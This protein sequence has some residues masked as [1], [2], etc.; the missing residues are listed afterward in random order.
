MIDKNK[1]IEILKKYPKGLKAK[2]IADFIVGVDR[3]AINQ[4]LYANPNIFSCNS[5]YEWTLISNT[6]IERKAIPTSSINKEQNNYID[7][8]VLQDYKNYYVKVKQGEYYCE[9]K[10]R[11]GTYHYRDIVLKLYLVGE[12]TYVVKSSE[13]DLKCPF[14]GNIFSV[15]SFSCPK[16]GRTMQDVCEKLYTDGNVDGQRF[17]ITERSVDEYSVQERK[18]KIYEAVRSFIRSSLPSMVCDY[19]KEALDEVHLN[20]LVMIYQKSL[21]IEKVEDEINDEIERGKKLVFKNC[22]RH[23][24]NDNVEAIVL[25]WKYFQKYLEYRAGS[26]RLKPSDFSIMLKISD[27]VNKCVD[28]KYFDG[29]YSLF[30]DRA[31]KCL[32]AAYDNNI[33][34][35]YKAC[36]GYLIYL[37]LINKSTSMKYIRDMIPEKI[38]GELD[39]K[40]DTIYQTVDVSL[41]DT[42]EETDYLRNY[43]K[44]CDHYCEKVYLKIPLLLSNGAIIVRTVLGTYCDKCK[45]YFVLDTEFKKILCEG[46]IQAQISFSESGEHFSGMDLSPES[47]LRKCGYT[48]SA[49]ANISTEHRQRLLKAII[50]NKLYTPAKIVTH[51]RF[52]ISINNNVTTRDMSVAISK[53]QEDIL[54]LQQHYS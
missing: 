40:N 51:F 10:A 53:W 33:L 7:R 9:D 46:R 11:P 39:L 49:N 19:F 28:V 44:E 37:A 26:Y 42:I 18:R 54:Y 5:N 34:V 38:Y 8:E 35:D 29:L 41:R 23:N 15:H 6:T 14:C 2:D 12:K 27:E 17:Y 21:G 48:V 36:R 30:R 1:I 16:C 24:V 45:K 4:I 43:H 22:I 20:T 25:V 3:K 31:K 50:D 32:D 13:D 52:L 47:L